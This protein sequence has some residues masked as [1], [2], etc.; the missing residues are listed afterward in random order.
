MALTAVVLSDLCDKDTQH[1][2]FAVLSVFSG[3]AR[4]VA[5]VAGKTQEL[6]AV[7]WTHLMGRCDGL[8]VY[9]SALSLSFF[10]SLCHS[11]SSSLVLYVLFWLQVLC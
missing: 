3:L 10:L 2:G 11:L 1:V 4:L 7:M 6:K 5:P 9:M 8:Y